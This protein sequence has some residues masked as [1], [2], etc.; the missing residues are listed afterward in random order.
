MIPKIRAASLMHFAQ[1][2]QNL[3]FQPDPILARVGFD[4]A[5]LQKA[6]LL[7]PALQAVQLL[8]YAAKITRCP[9]FGLRLAEQRRLSGFGLVG[10]L[11]AHQVTL[12]DGMQAISDYRHLLN[13]IT[14]FY[15][16]TDQQEYRIKI[17]VMLNATCIKTQAVELFVAI[18]YRFGAE[19]IEQQWRPTSVHFTHS[20]PAD[21]SYHQRFFQC[22]VYFNSDF[23]GIVCPESARLLKNRKADAMLVAHAKQLLEPLAQPRQRS[24]TDEI[25]QLFFIQLPAGR[26]HIDWIARYLSIKP[27]T[28]Q[29]KLTELNIS[30]QALLNEVRREQ[31]I[32]YLQNQEYPVQRIANLLGYYNANSFTRWFSAEFGMTPSQYRQGLSVHAT[33]HLNDAV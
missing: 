24:L 15:T 19:L 13:D 27:R 14:V 16:E 17:D 28:L 22:P 20:E 26:H 32:H 33:D 25:K 10:L 29:R 8:E 31:C 11:L 3:G 5:M 9:S 12:G 1:V 18:A 23:N 7:L 21:I 30:Y 4:C 6:E 2:C